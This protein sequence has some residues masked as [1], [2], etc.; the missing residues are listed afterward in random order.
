M[1][2]PIAVTSGRSRF[3]RWP[4]LPSQLRMASLKDFCPEATFSEA[5]LA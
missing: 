5:I 2:T 1:A 3:S 4:K